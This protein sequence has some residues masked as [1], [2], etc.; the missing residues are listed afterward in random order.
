MTDNYQPV[1]RELDSAE[2]RKV[3]DKLEAIQ[4]QLYML[5]AKVVRLDERVVGVRECVVRIVTSTVDGTTLR[6]VQYAA[7]GVLAWQSYKW[8]EKWL[9]SWADY[10]VVALVFVYWGW[11]A[12]REARQYPPGK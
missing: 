9:G 1:P 3:F 10:A 4:R 2:L 12:M 5:D 11:A 6:I 7:I 8:L